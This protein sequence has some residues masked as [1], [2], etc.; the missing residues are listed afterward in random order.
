[1]TAVAYLDEI[2]SEAGDKLYL[3]PA[4]VVELVG[5]MPE[6]RLPATGERVRAELALAFPYAPAVGDTLLVIGQEGKHYVI[7]V[8]RAQGEVSL[9]FMGDVSIH[10]VNGELSLGADKRVKMRA[11]EVETVARK[12]KV[13]AESASH[14]L[15]SFYQRVK[16]TL[17]V[18]AGQRVEL[19]D[20]DWHTRAERIS[21]VTRG[22]VSINGEQVHLN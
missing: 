2:R 20:D 7:G 22:V 6:I 9:R 10:A 16:Q 18:H 3:G 15:G 4:E 5:G 19:T 13:L 11:P 12:V 21:M 8:L 1:M 17:R 14:K